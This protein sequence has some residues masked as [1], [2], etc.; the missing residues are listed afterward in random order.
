M[1]RLI[2]C[3][4]ATLL[5]FCNRGLGLYHIS[6][7][8][9]G[10]SYNISVYSTERVDT[11]SLNKKIQARLNLFENTFSTYRTNSELSRINRNKST[12]NIFISLEMLKL[13][14]QSERIFRKTG[15][16]FDITVGP[17]VNLWGFGPEKK[18]IK[19]IPRREIQETLS[20]IGFHRVK[21]NKPFIKKTHKDVHFDFSAIA[22]GLAVDEVSTL[23]RT[24]FNHFLVEIGGEVY[25]A[26]ARGERAWQLGIEGL[27]AQ[28]KG[29]QKIVALKDKALATSGDYRNFFHLKG[30][31]YA[32]TINPKTGMPVQHS[33]ASVSV[34]TDRCGDAD[35]LATA[36]LVMGEKKGLAFSKEKKLAV[37]F[38]IRTK[39]GQVLEKSSPEMKKYII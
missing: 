22:K 32:H 7:L 16:A 15:G 5:A 24:R 39:S 25:A 34:I 3:G 20:Y 30:K 10:T 9:M 26:G 28:S 4:L 19:K 35:A 13:F 12:E 11:D 2:L 17:L 38:L 29:P 21:I 23:L 1:P 6:G 36:L 33:L 8:T 37:L 18:T 31:R 14:I 27:L